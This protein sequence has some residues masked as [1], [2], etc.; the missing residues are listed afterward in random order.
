MCV[1]FEWAYLGCG[2]L[3]RVVV[4]PCEGHVRIFGTDVGLPAS[5]R[6]RMSGR[7]CRI[8][9]LWTDVAYEMCADCDLE[10]LEHQIRFY[11]SQG[12]PFGNPGA[13]RDDG[14]DCDG[15]AGG[16]HSPDREQAP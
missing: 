1:R 15:Q 13:R 5:V 4:V 2:H 9:K 6:C 11:A 7:L 16:V 12:W 3:A 14:V 10:L 8:H